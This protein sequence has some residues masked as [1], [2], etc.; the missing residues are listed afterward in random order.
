MDNLSI[1]RGKTDYVINSKITIH[2]PTLG[3]IE[4]YGE[5]K[6]FSMIHNL[7]ATG[8]D[9]KY[10][11]NQIGVDYSRITDFEIFY[12]IMTNRYSKNDT[13]ILFGDL[14]L[15][16]F[17][18]YNNSKTNENFL[19]DEVNDTIIDKSI[20]TLIVTY[21]RKI[22]YMKRNDEVP[23]NEATKLI[24][25]DEAKELYE[26]NKNK[27]YHSQLQ[28]LIS[29][30]VNSEG[31]KYNWDTVWN[32]KIYSFMDS[33][34]RIVH[35]ENARLLLQSGYSGFGIDLKKIDNENINWLGELT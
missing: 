7:C 31:F 13:K 32:L 14:D 11:L 30:M 9:L 23:Y 21:L 16:L 24:L 29:A 4:E 27:Q 2:Q 3:E 33:V 15:T 17:K 25:I 18:L 34:R 28:C 10:E 5:A 22:H 35:T 19:G 12:S 6:Y 1:Y 20:Y 26:K 8:A